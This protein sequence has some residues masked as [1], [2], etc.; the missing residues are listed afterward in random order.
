MI[1]VDATS[2]VARILLLD[3]DNLG[4]IFNGYKTGQ[5]IVVEQGSLLDLT[6]FNGKADG[7][8]EFSFVYSGSMRVRAFL[9]STLM[10]ILGLLSSW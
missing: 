10:L 3:N 1:S 6:L 9:G 2:Y 4:V 7:P 5:W 8:L